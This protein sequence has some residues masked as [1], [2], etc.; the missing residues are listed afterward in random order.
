MAQIVV[1]YENVGGMVDVELTYA[2]ILESLT[3]S[4]NA[5]IAYDSVSVISLLGVASTVNT[6]G[7]FAG[8]L[9]WDSSNNRLVRASGP[10]PADVWHVID[11]SALVTPV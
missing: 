5:A 8:K 10:L 6:T 1:V 4:V 3:N 9:L 11:G 2:A 7:K